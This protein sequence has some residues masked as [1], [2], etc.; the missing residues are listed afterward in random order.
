ML[1]FE[2][3]KMENKIERLLEKSV[4]NQ[5]EII[6]LLKQ[7]AKNQNR[8]VPCNNNTFDIGEV[9]ERIESPLKDSFK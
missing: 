4:K 9:A 7:I 5:T 6:K 8:D 2:E 3:V 1:I